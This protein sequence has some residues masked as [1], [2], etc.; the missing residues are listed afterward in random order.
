MMDLVAQKPA[1]GL[2]KLLKGSGVRIKDLMN[3][4]GFSR[5]TI[6]RHIRGVRAPNIEQREKY[7]AV[8]GV[9]LS[10]IHAAFNG[11]PLDATEEL[12]GGVEHDDE[13]P[14]L[15]SQDRLAALATQFA[16]TPLPR[17]KGTPRAD[18]LAGL[19]PDEKESLARE[20]MEQAAKDRGGGG[21]KK[22]R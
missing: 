15:T 11:V 12:H 6:S 17:E 22:K 18:H 10:V 5:P 1:T 13:T 3:R 20:L 2:K 9:P 14:A 4:T 7:A 16:I 19:T 21:G 8:L